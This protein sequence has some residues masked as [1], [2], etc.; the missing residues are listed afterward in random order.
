VDFTCLANGAMFA[1]DPTW[2]GHA[3]GV[4]VTAD[5]PPEY[6]YFNHGNTLIDVGDTYI[7][8]FIQNSS[9]GWANFPPGFTG[10][11]ISDLH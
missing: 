11:E 5:G 9:V 2:P 1:G 8:F 7:R 10:I 3:F 6:D 4:E